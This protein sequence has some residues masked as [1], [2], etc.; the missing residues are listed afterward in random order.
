MNPWKDILTYI[1]GINNA[2]DKHGFW[3][4]ATTW[5]TLAVTRVLRRWIEECPHK[6][7]V[8]NDGTCT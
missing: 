2:L 1:S 5:Y 7:V 4:R 3:T 6:G 8:L